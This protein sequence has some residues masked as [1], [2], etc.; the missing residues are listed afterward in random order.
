M[1]QVP[2]PGEQ[3]ALMGF[4]WQYD[5]IAR[6]AYDGIVD[7]DLRRIR[8]AST[9]AGQVDDLLID[10]E[11]RRAAY[12]FKS[13]VSK[14]TV[15][16]AD[17]VRPGRTPGGAASDSLWKALARGWTDLRAED[18]RELT[19]HLAM[20][21]VPS[22]S[23]HLVEV[24]L[25]PSPD[26]F[27]AFLARAIKP[28][29]EDSVDLGT[30]KEWAV[31]LKR[32]EEEA[33]LSPA[34]FRDFLCRVRLD[35]GQHDALED[36]SGSRRDDIASLSTVL[37]RIVSHASGTV[38]LSRDQIL[39]EMRW[40]D[41]K[42]FK[43]I[44]E[45]PVDRSRYSPL[46]GGIASLQ[47]SLDR[48]ETGY[49]A[50]TGP[51]G[52]GK[53]TLLTQTLSGVSD[54]VVRY[55]A[56]VPGAGG[57]A[58][59]R[60]SAE[61][62]LHDL[63]TML[64]NAG[65]PS[66]QKQLTPETVSD[67]RQLLSEQ[68]DAASAEFLATG[69]KTIVVVDGLDHVQR[70]YSGNDALTGELLRPAEIPKGIIFLVGTRDLVPLPSEAKQFIEHG[71]SE[72]NLE[73]H[74]LSRTAILDI[75]R[76]DT[77]TG[78][79][80][81]AIHELIADRSAGHPLALAYLLNQLEETD[82]RDLLEHLLGIP[83]YD[84]DIAGQ[85]RAVWDQLS[86]DSGVV[87]L[88][89]ICSRLRI[90]FEL[91]WIRTWA[92]DSA[93]HQLL[94]TLRFLFRV[95]RKRWQFF[96]DSFRQFAREMTSIGEN[97]KPDQETD[98]RAHIEAAELC[99][100]STS[101]AI[102]WQALF[103]RSQARQFGEV[104]RLG[105][106]AE[107]RRQF[108]HLRSASHIA[109]DARLVLSS[110]A[111]E[112]DFPALLRGLLILS[113]VQDKADELDEIDVCN[114][115]RLAGRVDAA[116]DF[117]GDEQSLRVPLSRAY[118]LASELARQS[119]PA[120]YRIFESIHHFGLEQPGLSQGINTNSEVAQAWA[121]CAAH[122]LPIEISLAR[123]RDLVPATPGEKVWQFDVGYRLFA[124]LVEALVAELSIT[125]P[126]D[127][128]AV[129]A[130]IVDEVGALKAKGL[131]SD[132]VEHLSSLLGD[133]RYRTLA[134][135]VESHENF[136]IRSQL[137]ANLHASLK[138]SPVYQSTLLDMAQQEAEYMSSER[139]LE[140][141]LR[142]KYNKALVLDDLSA[143]GDDT[144]IG[145]RLHYWTLRHALEIGLGKFQVQRPLTPIESVKPSTKTPAGN[146]ITPG[147]PVHSFSNAILIASRIDRLVRTLGL[148]RALVE[149]GS[150]VDEE[151]VW[152]ALGGTMNLFP[153][154][155][156]HAK[157]WSSMHSLRAKRQELNRLT[158]QVLASVSTGLL[159]RYQ[160]ALDR[161]FESQPGEWPAAIRLDLGLAL[162][163]EGQ[164]PPWLSDA[165]Q[166]F[167]A[168]VPSQGV[169]GA[170]LDL[171]RLL[172]AFSE[173]GD[174]A[175]A[176]RVASELP[177][178]ALGLGSRNDHQLHAWIT[179]FGRAAADL[180]EI[181]L[182]NTA[183]WLAQVLTAAEPLTDDRIGGDELPAA[184]AHASPAL[185][186]EIFEYM[187][188]N[189][190]ISH[191]DG[192][193]KLLAAL[194]AT[195]KLNSESVRLA[196][197]LTA[198][199]VATAGNNAHPSLGNE[200]RDRAPRQVLK[201]LGAAIQTNA[202]PTTRSTWLQALSVTPPDLPLRDDGDDK[203]Y[204]ALELTDGT[205]L[206]RRQ[207]LATTMDLPALATLVA[208][209]KR[210]SRFM[211]EMVL[212][213]NFSDQPIEQ[214][215]EV[216]E[217]TDHLGKVLLWLAESQLESGNG[218][219]G[220]SLAA[221]AV[222]YLPLD[223]WTTNRDGG[224]RRAIRIL[225]STN[226]LSSREAA[227]D[228]ATFIAEERW[229]SYMLHAELDDIFDAMSHGA[230]AS[231]FWPE[232]RE[233]LEGYADLLQL[234]AARPAPTV[235]WWAKDNM[236]V[237]RKTATLNADGVLGEL[238]AIHLTHPAWPV[239][240]GIARIIVAALDRRSP[241][242]ETALARLVSSHA[243]D[244]V[245]ES[246]AS[247]LAAAESHPG[248]GEVSTEADEILRTHP[249]LIVRRLAH[250]N[251][252]LATLRRDRPL[253]GSYGLVLPDQD[254][255]SREEFFGEG[256][257]FLFPFENR[258][259]LLS[260]ATGLELPT[261]H[262]VAARYASAALADLPPQ[263]LVI[264]SLS[265]SGM[266]LAN[267]TNVVLASRS[268]FGRVLGDLVDAGAIRT[269]SIL[270][271]RMLRTGDSQLVGMPRASKPAAMPAAPQAGHDQTT[272]RWLSEIDARIEEYA[273]ATRA[274]D[275]QLVGA[276]TSL[277]VLN[278][279]HLEEE[280]YC[281]LTR[282]DSELGPEELFSGQL[283]DL[284]WD[285]APGPIDELDS[286]LVENQGMAFMERR[287]DWMAIHPVLA[288]SLGWVPSAGSIGRWIHGADVT[289]YTTDWN[290]GTWG[291]SGPM[292]DDTTSEGFATVIS[293]DALKAV[294]ALVGPV[295]LLLVL[296]RRDQRE[297]KPARETSRRIHL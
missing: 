129:D 9:Q 51:P 15:T 68:L 258:Y 254:M 143:S 128:L 191:T 16:F 77:A 206:T 86:H 170:L 285:G 43:G 13:G 227:L 19:V 20:T 288:R 26:H 178:C 134:A 1:V 57:G 221:R 179:W 248:L 241:D 266:K 219:L 113:E 238:A 66:R 35:L 102:R 132:R 247:C 8:L 119:N 180:D 189:S 195:G 73:H 161:R 76:S 100:T 222:S 136:E 284:A 293:A 214:V 23:D 37:S 224:R 203:D 28:L 278:R 159:T 3:S 151:A 141:L 40:Q 71:R 211:W 44:H 98:I 186:L 190:A 275:L 259:E 200:L 185:A 216:F 188:G 45:F 52:S 183:L 74:R 237:A 142:T 269:L 270:G 29:R 118:N 260:E 135:H 173:L 110:A 61:W 296:I 184:I 182:R 220:A 160:A 199:I 58:R 175:E 21:A 78:N 213:S 120:G 181:D 18:E 33:G 174:L 17:L 70:D 105:T 99:E 145:T 152:S 49:V 165:L 294:K 157:D 6:L 114:A 92:S 34:D 228:F 27:R 231:A 54:R 75:C 4:R 243:S 242:V 94:T 47:A 14:A 63:S 93:V 171:D 56:F 261:I 176:A 218:E 250:R 197:D 156:R 82:G 89:R 144:A 167:E 123:A 84:G 217:G 207:V 80:P 257:P 223:S 91:D 109:D 274:G 24:G 97:R 158:I 12:Q 106:Q 46:S 225:V 62:F 291:R 277:T 166:K 7:S 164:A 48:L 53:S 115:L 263:D 59:N 287:S 65:L 55:Y 196:A 139:S 36:A 22:T 208:N 177:K 38:E 147:A 108:V 253:S 154:F 81:E 292:F 101:D 286:L 138:G 162:H 226:K 279:P 83:A 229:Y 72:V 240:E 67:L 148:V 121:R 234:P 131:E 212:Q 252:G 163:N 95:E 104:L 244:D 283:S 42:S 249:N 268:A 205:K 32:L 90:G 210:D 246:I 235:K 236:R 297:S 111:E 193:S 103:H 107:F 251:A 130:L 276:K 153:P 215:A 64:R 127:L 204:N 155:E 60:L 137:F 10:F 69:R 146:N 187:V 281:I 256:L 295:D 194:L 88:L 25:R 168:E 192:L 198:E 79:M 289:A 96:H 264:D 11:S 265:G 5:H 85:Y 232:I 280:F 112:G 125:S 122:F 30:L 124:E 2:L 290:D 126:G 133:L 273:A 150:P 116:I 169:N 239:R 41:R 255:F 245:L 149:T 87:R 271:E 50:V 262:A 117:V 31:P 172:T 267:P 140:T 202:L 272:D 282:K 233:Y 209:E 230:P 201:S 39:A